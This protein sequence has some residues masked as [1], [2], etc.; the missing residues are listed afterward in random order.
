MEGTLECEGSA[1]HQLASANAI[2]RDSITAWRYWVE[3]WSDDLNC[4]ILPVSSRISKMPRAIRAT[5]PCPLGG[6]SQISRPWL[7]SFVP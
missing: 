4:G 3:L 5:I 1:I 7:S 2:R 6:C